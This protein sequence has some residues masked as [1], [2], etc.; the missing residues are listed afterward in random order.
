MIKLT[1]IYLLTGGNLGDRVANLLE[2]RM[3]LEARVGTI[4]KASHLYETEAW[5][6]VDQPAYLNQ[7]LELETALSPHAVLDAIIAIEV[8]LG[9]VRRSKWE[10]RPIDI[11]V[12]FFGNR[13]VETPALTIPHPLLHR[14][15]FALIPM[16]EIAPLKRHPVLKKTIEELY[17]ASEDELDV[18]LMELE[19]AAV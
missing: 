13:I 6:N 9:R 15:N 11:D 4:T 10:A 8:E 14:R 12:L 5:G 3:L 18:V 7:A 16:L 2:A 17:E 19:T 1:K